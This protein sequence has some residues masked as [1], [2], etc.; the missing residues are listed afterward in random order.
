MYHITDKKSAVKEVQRLLFLN[1]TGIYDENTRE[2]VKKIQEKCGLEVSGIVDFMTFEAIKEDFYRHNTKNTVQTLGALE[3]NEFPYEFGAHSHDVSILNAMLSNKIDKYSLPL[4]K[5]RGAFY[6]KT[7]AKAVEAMR[8]I[9]L[10]E[11]GRYIDE[12][13]YDKLN[14]W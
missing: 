8:E 13:F 5:P 14:S 3:L 9:F 7:T 10:L 2:T 12:I 11:K 6:S 1:Q 4:W